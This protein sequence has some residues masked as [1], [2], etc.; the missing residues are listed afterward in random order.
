MPVLDAFQ[1]FPVPIDPEID[2][3]TGQNH[4]RN[5]KVELSEL[6]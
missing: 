3:D 2:L 6:L 1:D 4:C 5:E